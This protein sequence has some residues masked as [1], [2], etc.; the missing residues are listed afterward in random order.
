MHIRIWPSF[1]QIHI[2]NTANIWRVFRV[3]S[4][5]SAGIT[6]PTLKWPQNYS[7]MR[8]YIRQNDTQLRKTMTLTRQNDPELRKTM[9]ITREM[10]PKC[11]DS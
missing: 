5:R 1:P 4:K 8:R 6:K 11:E 10:T 9:P 3:I 2:R 7:E